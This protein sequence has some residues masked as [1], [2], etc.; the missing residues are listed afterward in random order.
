MQ[1]KLATQKL[2]NKSENKLLIHPKP[3]PM[4]NSS[5]KGKLKAKM[6]SNLFGYILKF[7]IFFLFLGLRHEYEF[8]YENEIGNWLSQES[9]LV[10]DTKATSSNNSVAINVAT[11]EA[12]ESTSGWSYQSASNNKMGGA[13]D[14]S[15]P[16]KTP[17]RAI[18]RPKTSK[19]ILKEIVRLTNGTTPKVNVA[20]SGRPMQS[21][22]KI[23]SKTSEMKNSKN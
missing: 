20:L 12:E 8:D 2:L 9:S 16:P 13:V 7:L 5:P 11:V 23:L 19:E 1:Q 3:A 14:L 22:E 18:S 6:K 15:L 10:F 21:F 4:F 17:P